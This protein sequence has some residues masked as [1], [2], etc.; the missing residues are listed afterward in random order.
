VVVYGTAEI[1]VTLIAACIPV[2]RVLI[3][4]VSRAGTIRYGYTARTHGS[5]AHSKG[6]G[7]NNDDSPQGTLASR[8]GSVAGSEVVRPV[9]SQ[10]RKTLEVMREKTIMIEYSC[11]KLEN[12]TL[13][14]VN[15]SPRT[16]FDEQF[17]KTMR[18]HRDSV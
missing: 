13:D 9:S 18:D 15:L 1:A 5:T 8:N 4:D 17:D 16:L 10:A 3:R 7:S 2:L 6:S 14:P 12:W 11:A